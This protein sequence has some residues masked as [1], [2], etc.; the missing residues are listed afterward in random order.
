MAAVFQV[1]KGQ[2]QV[3]LNEIIGGSNMAA[4]K[5]HLFVTAVTP[6]PS[7][8]PGD[9]TEATWTGYSPQDTGSWSSAALDGNI[10]FTESD[11]MSFTVTSGGTGTDVHGYYVTDSS[12]SNV[13]FAEQ[14]DT[15]IPVIDGVPFQ[16]L[17]RYRNRNP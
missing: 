4:A 17:I 11:L 14:F 15:P 12:S 1:D 6:D 9:F 7:M 13:L 5:C 8:V 10:A 3:N 16:L 2:L